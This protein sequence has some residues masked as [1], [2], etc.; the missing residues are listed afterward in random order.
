MHE[1]FD[2]VVREISVRRVEMKMKAK[3]RVNLFQN[4]NA[5]LFSINSY[6]NA[7]DHRLHL[8]QVLSWVLRRVEVDYRNYQRVSANEV[9]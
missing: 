9:L 7:S 1:I 4:E 3:F 8:S 6:V 2:E 5:S